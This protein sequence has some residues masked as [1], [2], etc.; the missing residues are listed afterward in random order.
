MQ[1]VSGGVGMPRGKCNVRVRSWDVQP[2]R[3]NLVRELWRGQQLF[4]GQSKCLHYL[5]PWLNHVRWYERETYH[6]LT[7][8]LWPPM[9]WDQHSDGVRPGQVRRGGR[10]GLLRVCL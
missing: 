7:V 2:R 4:A 6:V 5:W 8:R 1:R 9:R 3:I 10:T